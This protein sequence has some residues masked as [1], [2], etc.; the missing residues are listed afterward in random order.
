[1]YLL[2]FRVHAHFILI[3]QVCI[4]GFISL[5]LNDPHPK[6]YDFLN[7][8]KYDESIPAS[9]VA[10]Y[11][12]FMEAEGSISHEVHTITTSI[13]LLSKV[14][15]LINKHMETQ[16]SGEWMLVAE[17]KD[18]VSYRQRDRYVSLLFN[19]F[20]FIIII[21]FTGQYFS[22]NYNHRLCFIICCLYISLWRPQIQ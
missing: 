17:W 8:I 18:V 3:N 7:N 9:L 19:T 10:P 2:K 16:F 15:S 12:A 1:M 21:F 22:G 6:P 13:S 11:S 14:N 5:G 4:D 20:I